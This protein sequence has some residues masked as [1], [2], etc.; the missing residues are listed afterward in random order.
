[1]FKNLTN[2][3][4]ILTNEYAKTQIVRL[5]NNTITV[6]STIYPNNVQKYYRKNA[7]AFFGK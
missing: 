5:E 7:R 3:T 1:M 4:I 2:D 6:N